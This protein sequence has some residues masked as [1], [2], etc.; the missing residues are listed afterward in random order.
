MNVDKTIPLNLGSPVFGI[1]VFFPKSWIFLNYLAFL[2]KIFNF[3][4]SIK[5]LAKISVFFLLRNPRFGVFDRKGEKSR[6]PWQN[7][8]EL[9]C[10]NIVISD[11][12][13]AFY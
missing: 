9:C 10:T 7:E 2:A 5:V 8:Q 11:I 12:K 4:E 3:I 6:F 1:L 13:Y